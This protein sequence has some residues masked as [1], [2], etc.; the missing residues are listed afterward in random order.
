MLHA[1]SLRLRGTSI[2]AINIFDPRHREITSHEATIIQAFADV[3]TIGILQERLV[4][5]GAVLTTQLNRALATPVVIEQ[6][7]GIVAEHLKTTM[8]EAFGL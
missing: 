8:D 6:A 5:D 3:A 1:F 4:S 2:G 7:K